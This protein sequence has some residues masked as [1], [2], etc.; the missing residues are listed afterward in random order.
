MKKRT[1]FGI[2]TAILLV[3]EVII[4]MYAH[5]WVRNYLGDALVVILLYTLIRTIIPDRSVRWYVL[6]AVILIFAFCVEF[7]QLWGLCDRLGITNKLLR[8]LIGTGFSLEDLAAYTLGI[9]PC[10][11]VEFFMGKDQLIREKKSG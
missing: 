10:F 1:I 6:P 11:V 8:I 9:I 7:L 4:G 2:A 3:I 5:G